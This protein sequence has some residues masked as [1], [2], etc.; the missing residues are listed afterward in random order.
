MTISFVVRPPLPSPEHFGG[1]INRELQLQLC[2]SSS[3]ATK[4]R[5]GIPIKAVEW[6]H[7]M[8]GVPLHSTPWPL[9]NCSLRTSDATRRDAKAFLDTLGVYLLT[10]YTTQTNR[11]PLS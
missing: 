1:D 6:L 7:S 5:C 10:S 2:S 9:G 11:V 3:H 4:L 8:D